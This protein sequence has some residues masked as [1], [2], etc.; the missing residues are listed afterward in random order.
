LAELAM[1]NAAIEA[2]NEIRI[3]R[4]NNMLILLMMANG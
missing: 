1:R 3:I 2:E 4:N